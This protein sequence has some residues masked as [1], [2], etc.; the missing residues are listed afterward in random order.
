M[1][2]AVRWIRIIA[3]TAVA[4]LWLVA[5]GRGDEAGRYTGYVEAEFVY[6]AA[7]D[8][9]WIV[10]APVRE[11]SEVK[12]GDLLFELD[13]DRQLAE[14]AEAEQ[15]VH[16]T[17]ALSQD[18]A[19]GARTDEIA[20]LEARLNEAEAGLRLAEL[21]RTRWTKLV[22]RGVAPKARADRV[23][24]DHHSAEAR[25]HTARANIRVARLAGRRA[26]RTAAAARR[27]AAASALVQAKWRLDERSIESKVGG[28][29]KEVFH[30]AGEYVRVG[31][32]ILALLPENAIKV[33]FFVPQS[34]LSRVNVGA[35]VDVLIDGRDEP[36]RGQITH[37]AREAE[38]T[39]PVIFS[40]E[41]RKK[42]V[43]LVE[44]HLRDP[45]EA[46]PGQPVDVILR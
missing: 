4:S 30:R 40:A 18:L 14:V 29:V 24:A 7:P 37:I 5:C 33:R 6:V 10:K 32:P 21:E 39:P 1:T 2:Q 45:K 23:I 3:V 44:A 43:F 12:V 15:R 8:S 17:A 35:S 20:A 13:T 28:R 41:S 46:R 11:G 22:K 36:T 26:A 25:V 27:D 38:F 31:S 19:T 34:A 42:L 16:E 9:G